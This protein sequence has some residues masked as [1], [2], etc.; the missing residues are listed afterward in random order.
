MMFNGGWPLIV[1]PTVREQ[2]ESKR[3]REWVVIWG[4]AFLMSCVFSHFQGANKQ[5][6]DFSVI[7]APLKAFKDGS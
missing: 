5:M 4:G 3:E 6:I 1:C 7:G 2:Q